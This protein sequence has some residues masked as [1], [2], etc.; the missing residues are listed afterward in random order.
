MQ[1]SSRAGALA[2]HLPQE[3]EVQRL[4]TTL[5]EREAREKARAEESARLK[6]EIEALQ[7][8]LEAGR[9]AL[10]VLQRKR[11]ELTGLVQ[12]IRRL[13]LTAHAAACMTLPFFLSFFR[14]VCCVCT[15]CMHAS[16]LDARLNERTSS[17][18]TNAI[19]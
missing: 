11:A 18:Q 17:R 6:T 13:A 7:A 10:D 2:P 15:C 4:R 14:C 8:G 19:R 5:A 1:S 12:V 9:A 3:K 16:Q